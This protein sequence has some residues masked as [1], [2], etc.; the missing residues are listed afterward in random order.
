M[1][2][3]RA[4]TFRGRPAHARQTDLLVMVRKR[5]AARNGAGEAAG[6]ATGNPDSCRQGMCHLHRKKAR[7]TTTDVT[8]WLAH[9]QQSGAPRPLQRLPERPQCMDGPTAT[10]TVGG[11]C[12]AAMDVSTDLTGIQRVQSGCHECAGDL[13]SSGCIRTLRRLPALDPRPDP[14]APLCSASLLE[15]PP[16]AGGTSSHEQRLLLRGTASSDRRRVAR[17]PHS[18]D[19]FRPSARECCDG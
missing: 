15:H 11:C 12:R 18:T 10:V 17:V 13:L 16:A 19:R 7:R 2:S 5:F 8:T 1:C 14:V 6:F 4:K 3:L 9:R